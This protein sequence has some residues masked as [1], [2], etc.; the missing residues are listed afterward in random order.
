[1]L[2]VEG[3]SPRLSLGGFKGGYSLRKESIPLYLPVSAQ[4]GNFRPC[5]GADLFFKAVFQR[6]RSVE[7]QMILGAILVIKAEIPKAHEL[8]ARRGLALLFGLV[9]RRGDV[10]H[11]R[12]DLAAG[13]HL[14]RIGVHAGKEI[15]VRA[16]GCGVAEQLAVNTH[17]GVQRG[18][19]VDPVDRRALNLAAVGG[20][21]ARR[22]RVVLGV[23]LDDVAIFILL[24]A[25]AG[26]EVRAL[27]AALRSAEQITL[28]DP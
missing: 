9:V 6:H 4:R 25:R 22:V 3:L 2:G 14:E 23:D 18:R 21:A 15:L 24:A 19:G 20:I 5:T 26:D 16:V 10:A 11:A 7:H 28:N 13:Q 27:E 17:L 1:M 12:L 8:K